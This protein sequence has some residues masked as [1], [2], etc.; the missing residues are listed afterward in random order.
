MT[1]PLGAVPFTPRTASSIAV[2]HGFDEQAIILCRASD[3]AFTARE[4]ILDPIPL[5]VS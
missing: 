2:E 1:D 5:V 3:M 4:K